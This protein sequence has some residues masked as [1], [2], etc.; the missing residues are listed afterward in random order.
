MLAMGRVV[1]VMKKAMKMRRRTVVAEKQCETAGWHRTRPPGRAD[2]S[3]RIE[4]SDVVAAAC[5]G[6]AHY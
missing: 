6:N 4:V 2:S 5:T 3:R 1:W